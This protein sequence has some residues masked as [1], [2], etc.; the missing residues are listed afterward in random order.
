MLLFLYVL[1]F[2]YFFCLCLL[3]I[4]RKYLQLSIE[5][6]HLPYR[7]LHCT[8]WH[9]IQSLLVCTSWDFSCRI[10][11]QLLKIFL[12]F[13]GLQVFYSTFKD[14][15][16]FFEC[17]I[18]LIETLFNHLVFLRSEHGM[19]D[20]VHDFICAKRC[21]FLTFCIGNSAK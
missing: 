20:D 6:L 18:C 8:L 21:S 12:F 13:L 11:W 5:W 9:L 3:T 17:R 7:I 16:H 15:S 14:I 2:F 10:S 4:A 19:V 1:K